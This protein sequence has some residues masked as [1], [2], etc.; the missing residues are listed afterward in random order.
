MRFSLGCKECPT[1]LWPD[2]ME[3]KV[4]NTPPQIRFGQHLLTCK[5]CGSSFGFFC[6]RG[7]AL[8]RQV[9]MELRRNGEFFK[10]CRKVVEIE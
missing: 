8:L 4:D 2:L 6:P 7:E 10:E 9:V 1:D 5:E 3:N